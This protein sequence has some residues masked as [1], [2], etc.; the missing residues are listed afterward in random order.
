MMADSLRAAGGQ[1]PDDTAAVVVFPVDHALVEA[2]TV[3]VHADSPAS[4]DL[5]RAVRSV[6]G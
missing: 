1:L 4:V 5:A 2:E 6:L 3:C